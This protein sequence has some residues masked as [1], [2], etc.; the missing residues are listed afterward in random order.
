MS[1]GRLRVLVADDSTLVREALAALI[2][3]Q[4]SFVLI[5]AVADATEAIEVARGRRP[6]VVLLDVRMP[7]GGGKAAA[8]GIRR[9]SPE[10]RVIALSEHDDRATVLEMLEA[11]VIGYL[12]KGC[13]NKEIVAAVKSAGNGHG[14][15]SGNVTN[16]II[17]TL[18]GQLR[19]ES[20]ASQHRRA[21]VARVTR[22]LRDEAAFAMVFQPIVDLCSRTVVGAEALARFTGPRKRTPDLWFAEA[23]R[24]GLGME[25]EVAATRKAVRALEELPGSVYLTV[26]VSPA[27]LAAP[28]FC[29]VVKAVGGANLVAEITEHELVEDYDR[30]SGAI[31]KLRALG[32]RIAVDDAGA[33]FASFRHILELRPELIKLDLTLIREIDHDEARQALVAGL[34]AFARGSDATIIAEGI[35][36]ADEVETLVELGVS[37][38]QGYL[39]GRPAALPLPALAVGQATETSPNHGLRQA[40]AAKRAPQAAGPRPR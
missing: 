35:E 28:E 15:L 11:G 26:N 6:D 9:H 13:S 8:L 22:A 19:D 23:T 21:C 3:R 36:R 39:L 40:R 2:S 17:R 33:G 14:S 10:S 18:S 37:Y 16:D 31:G 25:L 7:G 34:I 5:G 4:P 12:V 27:T 20:R 29:E 32:M 24:I 30:V 1:S 38:G